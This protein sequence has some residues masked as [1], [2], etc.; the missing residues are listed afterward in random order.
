M[1][2]SHQY[3]VINIVVVEIINYYAPLYEMQKKGPLK[4]Q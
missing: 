4:L 2:N 3:Y 1:I